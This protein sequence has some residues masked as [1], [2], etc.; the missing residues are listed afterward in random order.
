MATLKIADAG[1]RETACLDIASP[2][3]DTPDFDSLARVYRWLEY[4]SFGPMLER[5]RFHFL[6]SCANARHA[7]VLGD[8][9][10]RF[11]ARLLAANRDVEIDAIDSSAAM[12]AELQHRARHSSPNAEM[13]LRTFHADLRDFTPDRSGY[14]LVVSHFFLDCLSDDEA[15]G[16]VA[17]IIPHLTP[18]ATWLIS[19]FAI[20]AK[21]LHRAAA[22]LIVRFLYFAFDK[23]TH[24]RVQK[25]PD[26]GRI[27]A[28]H[29]LR[30]QEQVPLL[31]GLL[32]TERWQRQDR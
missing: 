21:G 14:D 11:T 22:R 18:N 9:D 8:G 30:R 25:I 29:G 27:V 19:E 24:L 32:V 2:R 1:S 13:R 15:A 7:L 3:R 20:P 16:V 6:P 4:F 5:C 31:G 12:L 17:R 10:G 23:M 26:Y 28:L